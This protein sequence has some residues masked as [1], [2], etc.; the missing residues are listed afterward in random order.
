MFATAER[1]HEELSAPLYLQMQ[2]IHTGEQTITV[3]VQGRPVLAGVDPYHLLDWEEGE[4]DDNV[5]T[6]KI[7]SRGR[8]SQSKP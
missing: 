4:E 7:E 6:V 1:G 3:T 8:S 5:Q 2:R